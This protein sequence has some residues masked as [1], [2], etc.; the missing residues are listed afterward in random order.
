MI[1][2]DQLDGV[3][4]SV[5]HGK[6]GF[7]C[8]CVLFLAGFIAFV[9]CQLPDQ[10]CFAPPA[11]NWVAKTIN[12]CLLIEAI[13]SAIGFIA[14][15]IDRRKLCACLALGLFFPVFFVDALAKGCW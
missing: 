4:D 5:R 3:P 14:L 12:W 15:F 13:A 2:I 7:V 9:L 11:H 10:Y 1:I 8:L 6:I